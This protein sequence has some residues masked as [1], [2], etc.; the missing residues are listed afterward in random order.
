[1]GSSTNK[2][3]TALCAV[4]GMPARFAAEKPYPSSTLRG[5]LKAYM[6]G[7]SDA[8]LE[9]ISIHGSGISKEQA[10]LEVMRRAE[11]KEA[12]NA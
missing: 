1:M 5:S 3:A 2:L 11:G 4:L 12:P 6:Q 8:S 7:L 9:N 10:Q